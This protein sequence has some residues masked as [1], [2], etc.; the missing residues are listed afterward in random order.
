M[1]TALR[2]VCDAGD[3]G[4]RVQGNCSDDKKETR[5]MKQARLGVDLACQRP[6]RRA[7]PTS[8]ASSF[9]RRGSSPPRLLTWRSLRAKV[10]DDAEVTVVMEPTRNA[11]V[12]LGYPKAP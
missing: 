12:P 8:R 1:G 10:P 6:T 5:R 2:D 4:R 9:G 7:W 3:D 11:W